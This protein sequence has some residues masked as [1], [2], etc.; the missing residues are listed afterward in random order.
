M[1][2]TI[3]FPEVAAD[4]RPETPCAKR[5]LTAA[6]GALL[7]LLVAGCTKAAPAAPAAPQAMP[8]ATMPVSL[9]DVPQRDSYVAT[10]KS[11]RTTTLQPQVDGR[12]TRILVRSGQAVKAGDLLMQI[13]P[14][15][16]QAAVNQGVAT[17]F[18]QKAQLQYN[19][20]D[21][22]RQKALFEA[23]VISKQAYEQST[24]GFGTSTGAY[25]AAVASTATQREQLAYYQIRAPFAGIVGDVPVHQGDYVS[26]TTVLTTVDEDR[27]LEAYI[28]VPTERSSLVHAGLPVELLDTAGNT[29]TK[30]KLN[31]VSPQVDNGTQSILAKAPVSAAGNLRN[32]QIV[33]A[34]ITWD[35]KPGATVPILAVTRIGGAAFVYLATASSNGFTAHLTSVTLGDPVGNSYPV[36]TGLK[37]GDRVIVSGV[38]ML[39]EGAPVKPL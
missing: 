37:P 13:D 9:G 6:A 23:G 15:K 11:R 16:Q 38:Q 20:A 14:L 7:V 26:A 17:E 31:F 36:L 10:I 1:F 29:L 24:Q 25:N 30:T 19:Q 4:L 39:Q 3:R 22:A 32:Q 21:L 5:A 34:R 18:Q 12:I 33:N 2:R 27:D 35:S 8:V 28:Y